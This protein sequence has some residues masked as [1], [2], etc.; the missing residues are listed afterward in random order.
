[1]FDLGSLAQ[2][3]AAL[4][5]GST[6]VSKLMDKWRQN[7]KADPELKEVVSAL[8]DNQAALVGALKNLQANVIIPMIDIYKTI[9]QSVANH[10]RL[11]KPLADSATSSG[12]AIV[13]IANDFEDRLKQLEEQV[14]GKDN[15]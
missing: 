5:T 14:K 4:N 8:V 10:E 6:L 15:Q 2:V 11:L 3:L 13:R 1:M 12:D 7:P 9:A